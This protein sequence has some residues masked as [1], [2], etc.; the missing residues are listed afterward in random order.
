MMCIGSKMGHGKDQKER[1]PRGTRS[2]S[3]K[4]K[5]RDTID[6]KHRAQALG[7]SGNAVSKYFLQE[8][9]SRGAPA[10]HALPTVREPSS[11]FL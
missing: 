8:G 5:A 10:A 6:Q 7:T 1:A 9:G 3:S 4:K 2:E 11:A